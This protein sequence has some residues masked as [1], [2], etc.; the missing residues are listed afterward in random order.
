MKRI[1]FGLACFVFVAVAAYQAS[2]VMTPRLMMLLVITKLSKLGGINTITHAPRADENQRRIVMPSPDLLYSY[3]VFDL[4]QGP[5]RVHA[6]IPAETY[7]SLSAFDTQTDN[8]FV[9]DDRNAGSTTVDILL[10]ANHEQEAALSPGEQLVRSPSKRGLLLF[11][12]LVDRESQLAGVDETRK[13]A[14]CTAVRDM[15]R[16]S[17]D[18]R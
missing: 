8:F 7:W 13:R 1:G 16:P 3:C 4:R 11:R 14:T 15:Y 18:Q 9:V 10:A 6:D 2:I 12:T 5:L 17:S